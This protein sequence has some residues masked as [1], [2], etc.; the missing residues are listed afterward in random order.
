M[1]RKI[2]V[3]TCAA[4]LAVASGARADTNV[5]IGYVGPLS[6]QNAHIGKDAENGVRLAI[7][8]AN[9]ANVT[10]G[11]ATVRF[12]L[13]SQDDAADPKTAVVIAQKLVDDKVSGVVGDLN[14]GTTIPASKV[15][16]S[17]GIPQVS[18]SATNPTYTRQGFAT[19]F[20][21]IGDDNDVGR[22][23]AQ[24]M[25]R[26][27]RY[28]RVA[29]IDDGTAYGQG[30]ADV[31]SAELKANGVDVVAREFV[32]DKAIDFRGVLTS[33]KSKDAQAIFF[34]GLDG[35]AGPLR[36]QMN[37]LAMKTPLLGAG[38]QTDKF[39]Q[40]AGPE[41]AEGVVSAASGL[42][43][44]KLPR[45]KDFSTRFAKYGPVVLYSPYAYDATWALINAMKLANSTSPKEYLGAMTKVDFEGV[46]GQIAFDA[47][48]DLRTA[49]V[50]I[51][52]VD[53]GK[54]IPLTTY[55][56]K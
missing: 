14:S 16:A 17:A 42:P 54:F 1:Q 24:Y 52:E 34:G 12:L 56:Q 23:V 11:G 37:T 10:I 53:K 44:E 32:N 18:P 35:Q 40:L 15:Y 20:R 4:I 7:D 5:T 13:D 28:K 8:E 21:T 51:Y 50:T 38:I 41:A 3:I 45:G 39:V 31:V 30:L 2:L 33:I 6:G 36:K 9:S 26:T 55:S 25:A 43:L 46:T 49:N 22:C 27:K 19:A 29:I 48:G 47:K